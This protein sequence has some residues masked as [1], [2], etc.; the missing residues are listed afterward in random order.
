MERQK[1]WRIAWKCNHIFEKFKRFS[2]LK[3]T[4]NWNGN[5]LK[6]EIKTAQEIPKIKTLKR[7]K[8]CIVIPTS[9]LWN[10]FQIFCRISFLKSYEMEE[11][12]QWRSVSLDANDQVMY[13]GTTSSFTKF[14]LNRRFSTFTTQGTEK[15]ARMPFR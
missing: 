11:G 5:L 13:Y 3:R 9:T 15:I 7:K 12:N 1:T 6:G 10:K 4:S 2:N 14:H 8:L